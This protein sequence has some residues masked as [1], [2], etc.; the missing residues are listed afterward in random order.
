MDIVRK[1]I[2]VP[3]QMDEWIKTR[4][5]GHYTN[6]SEY[7]RDLIRHDMEERQEFLRI[8][9]ALEAGETSGVSDDNVLDVMAQVRQNHE[10]S[11]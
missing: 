10:K 11:R 2:T 8:K 3:K 6:D 5:E 9:A 7:L 1:T 4:I